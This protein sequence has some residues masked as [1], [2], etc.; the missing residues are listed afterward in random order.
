PTCIP[1]PDSK[2]EGTD[3]NLA[4]T[5]VLEKEDAAKITPA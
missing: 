1:K 4:D 5:K 3:D 2:E